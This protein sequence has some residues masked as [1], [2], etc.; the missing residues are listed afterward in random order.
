MESSPTQ[1]DQSGQAAAQQKSAQ[2][3]TVPLLA[4]VSEDARAETALLLV[5]IGLMLGKVLSSSLWQTRSD[6]V[7]VPLPGLEWLTPLS[8]MLS[9]ALPMVAFAL[10]AGLGPRRLT[11]PIFLL[12][13][14][15]LCAGDI[16]RCQPWVYGYTAMAAMLFLYCRQS[17]QQAGTDVLHREGQRCALHGA[18]L[19][20]IGTYF[21]SGLQKF[22]PEF[23]PDV[24][25]WMLQPLDKL[26]GGL[27]AGLTGPLTIAV[28][29]ME[30]LLG[31]LLCIPGLRWAGIIGGIAMHLSI[32]G[33]L[34]PL[35][36]NWNTVVWPWN[37][38]MILLLLVLF[39]GPARWS[40]RELLL[41]RLRLQSW[42]QLLSLLLFIML[43]LLSLWNL[44]PAY[45][46]SAL[47]CGNIDKGYVYMDRVARDA[48]PDEV[49]AQ[50]K[51]IDFN[52]YELDIYS[53]CFKRLNTPPF[54]EPATYLGIARGIKAQTG[55]KGSVEFTL[56]RR[57][58][59]GAREHEVIRYSDK[60]LER[61]QILNTE[62]TENT[63]Q[64]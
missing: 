5:L 35:G 12:V 62:N 34:G 11:G 19:I 17:G 46:S 20:I 57:R 2:T 32:L 18:R 25:A 10:A 4:W 42:P 7:N 58:V 53:W 3:G 50:L 49:Q 26:H 54:P 56:V 38:V 28:P 48:L 55:G 6:L 16:L 61:K 60:L 21:Y 41:P 30:M 51:Q 29:I 31:V 63:E 37:V 52:D 39:G 36:H 8:G 27:A 33:L 13:I 44:W 45:F 9:V 23:G 1:R 14:A 24:L 47:Y 64:D 40:T 15:L 22:T 59:I 43:P